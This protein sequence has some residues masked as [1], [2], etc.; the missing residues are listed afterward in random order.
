MS[1]EIGRDRPEVYALRQNG[2]NW[3]ISRREFLKAAGAGAA[4]LGAG[5]N[6]GCTTREKPLETVCSGAPSHRVRI[7]DLLLSADGKYLLSIDLAHDIKCWDLKTQVLLGKLPDYYGNLTTGYHDGKPC[8]FLC[9]DGEQVEY[10]E[11]PLTGELISVPDSVALSV[12]IYH[13][14]DYP[15]PDAAAKRM[16]YDAAGNLYVS[17]ENI[18]RRWRRE[19][20]YRQ[21]EVIYDQGS[22]W[23]LISS[24]QASIDGKRL[25]V[26]WAYGHGFG[27]LDTESGEIQIIEGWYMDFVP[28]EDG[29]RGLLCSGESYMLMSVDDGSIIWEKD[30]PKSGKAKDCAI[31]NAAVSSDGRSGALLMGGLKDCLLYLI[32][33]EDGSELLH[34][35]LGKLV[36]SQTYHYAGPVISPDGKIL[37]VSVDKTILFF[38]LPDL[39]LIGCPV[40]LEESKDNIKGLEYTGTDAATGESYTAVLPCGAALP[41]GAVCTCNCVAGRGGCSCDSYTPSHGGGGHY[42]HPN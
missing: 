42:W 6:S 1:G 17:R 40:D 18:I 14:A 34:C 15:T 3:I 2:E 11:L 21:S 16:T 20:G 36:P 9:S 26:R 10:L 33:M 31:Y 19:D 13:V 7:D 35:D 32:S 39:K 29:K 24:I 23:H 12:D 22:D 37:A 8:I 27:V 25:L 30:A 5:L 41:P 38:S 4:V 28:L